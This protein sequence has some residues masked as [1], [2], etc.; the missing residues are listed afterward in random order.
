M[1]GIL[2]KKTFAPQKF[3]CSYTYA[4]SPWILSVLILDDGGYQA[5]MLQSVD[6]WLKVNV[7]LVSKYDHFFKASIIALASFSHTG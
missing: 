3:A 2:G 5:S 6:L 7:D 4:R 1:W